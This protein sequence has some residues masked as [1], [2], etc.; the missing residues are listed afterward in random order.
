METSWLLLGLACYFD[1]NEVYLPTYLELVFFALYNVPP[2]QV[3]HAKGNRAR[4]GLAIYLTGKRRLP[5]GRRTSLGLPC[6]TLCQLCRSVQMELSWGEIGR[7]KYTRRSSWISCSLF[8]WRR[9]SGQVPCNDVGRHP[10]RVPLKCSTPRAISQMIQWLH[11]GSCSLSDR[12]F[13]RQHRQTCR[14]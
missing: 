3:S 11:S 1:L 10:A 5:P 9:D 4:D 14:A 6:K 12:W 8:E 13:Q 7:H 2:T